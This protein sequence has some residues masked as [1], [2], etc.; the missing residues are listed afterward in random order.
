MCH[1]GWLPACEQN[2]TNGAQKA[3]A[4]LFRLPL[5]M[6][7]ALAV[8]C[9]AL[10]CVALLCFAL[11][12]SERS[13]RSALLSM[14][15]EP[16]A[17]GPGDEGGNHPAPHEARP[18]RN[19]TPWPT[20]PTSTCA[21]SDT[22]PCAAA[23]PNRSARDGARQRAFFYGLCWISRC[24]EPQD[25]LVQLRDQAACAGD[26]LYAVAVSRS[27]A[28]RHWSGTAALQALLAGCMAMRATACGV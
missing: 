16:H 27:A 6:C 22:T 20:A 23:Q 28:A 3:L 19:R 21:Q 26:V 4:F 12:N 11:L 1:S 9:F 7:L 15:A 18:H 17:P 14:Q 13:A 25:Y 24:A 2:S 10:H 5:G 8:L